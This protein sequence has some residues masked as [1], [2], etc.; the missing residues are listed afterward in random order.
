MGK[1]RDLVSR[2][3]C[4]LLILLIIPWH[5][6]AQRTELVPLGDFEQWVVRDVEESLILGGEVK[7]LYEIGPTDTIVGNIAY[8]N[9]NTIW[10]TSNAYAKV[11]GITKTS[12]SVS[13]SV[14][15]DGTCA[16]LETRLETLKVLGLVSIRV[17]ISGSIF[18]GKVFEPIPGVSDPYSYMDW[19]IPFT[20]RPSALVLDYKSIVPNTGVITKGTTLRTTTF[21]GYDPE[22]I[23]LILQHRWEDEDGAIHAKRVGTAICHID[24]TSDGWKKDFRIPVIYGD[25]TK[26]PEY[27]PF[28]GL[29]PADRPLFALNSKGKSVPIREDEWGDPELPVTHALLMI[30]AGSWGAFIGAQGNVL[31]VD[32]IRLEF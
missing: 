19:G 3:R 14:G 4:A 21:E 22:Q 2:K 28:M 15:I 5:L 32:N 6:I 10:A 30:T 8:D 13:P 18:W 20:K 24:S 23:I 17:L 12:N 29:T 16:M 31:W 1:Y 27:K 7:R 11:V 25:A 9:D 26:H